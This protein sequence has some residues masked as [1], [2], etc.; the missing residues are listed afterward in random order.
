MKKDSLRT[1]RSERERQKYAAALASDIT[2]A[3]ERDQKVD[4]YERLLDGP[5]GPQSRDGLE[6]LIVSVREIFEYEGWDLPT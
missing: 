2:A 4:I 3:L 1:T 5:T 6:L